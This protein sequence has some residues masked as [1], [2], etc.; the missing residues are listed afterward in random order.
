[1][2]NI[3][4]SNVIGNQINYQILRKLIKL[5]IKTNKIRLTNLN[6]K[7]I[8]LHITGTYDQI[9]QNYGYYEKLLKLENY[10]E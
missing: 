6:R 9:R 4:N 1:M 2:K 10:P 7:E 3:L 5:K 8:W